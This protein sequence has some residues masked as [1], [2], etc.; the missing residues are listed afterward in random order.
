MRVIMMGPDLDVMGGVSAVARTLLDTQTMQDHQITYLPT[1]VDGSGLDKLGVLARGQ[2]E[3]IRLLRDEGPPDLFHIHVA[4]DTSFYRKLWFFQQALRTGRP[5]IVHV[6]GALV[7]TFYESSR[8][9]AAAIRWMYSRASRV[10]AIYPRFAD[11]IHDWTGNRARALALNNPI[12]V[13]DFDRPAD[14][15]PPRRPTVLFMGILGQR[16]GTWDLLGAIPKVLEAVPDALFRFGGNG[17]VQKLE[18]EARRMGISKNIEL[19]GW[20]RGDQKLRAF[21]E[22]HVYCLPSYNEVMPV[23]VIEAMAAS[24]PVIST[25]VAGIPD[26]VV[27]GETGYIIEPGDRAALANRLSRLLTDPALAARMGQAGR[28]RAET[29]FD[30]EVV[31]RELVRIWEEAVRG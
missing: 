5:I 14:L 27:D 29:H 31:A 3:L 16:K 1:A 19:L 2:R 30:D 8:I 15:P 25:D 10:I 24:L 4:A 18:S 17:E 28:R 7:I 6:H 11:I 9:H 13:A 23:S 22:A 20:L 21:Q 26:C 12:V